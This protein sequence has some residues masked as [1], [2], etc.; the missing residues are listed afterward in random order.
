MRF[1]ELLLIGSGET[2]VNQIDTVLKMYYRLYSIILKLY[3]SLIDK[4]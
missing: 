4:N 3:F 2:I 1:G